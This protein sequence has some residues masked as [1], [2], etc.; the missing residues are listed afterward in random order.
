MA[1]PVN[2]NDIGKQFFGY[3]D[4]L[5]KEWP[6]KDPTAL[7]LWTLKAK[8]VADPIGNEEQLL[9]AKRKGALVD[10]RC[11]PHEIIQLSHEGR[12]VP[13]RARQGQ[14]NQERAYGDQGN[15]VTAPSGDEIPGNPGKPWPAEW[16]QAR[17]WETDQASSADE[18]SP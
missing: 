16:S 13:L 7:L 6:D 12:L 4:L 18:P 9:S 10:L 8:T 14:I 1:G 15:F 11:G 2:Q 3:P 17:V 5:A